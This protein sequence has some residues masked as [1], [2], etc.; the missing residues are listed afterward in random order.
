MFV[1]RLPNELSDKSCE[2]SDYLSIHKSDRYCPITKH[3]LVP[4]KSEDEIT[5]HV[6]ECDPFELPLNRKTPGNRNK[7]T[8]LPIYE[9]LLAQ[10]TLIQ[11]HLEK[12][13]LRTGCWRGWFIAGQLPYIELDGITESCKK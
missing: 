2:R 11:E 9:N 6:W 3:F 13:R 12:T 7:R 1:R 4:H 8:K 5:K 10:M